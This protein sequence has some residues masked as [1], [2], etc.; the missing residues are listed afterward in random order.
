MWLSKRRS[1]PGFALL[2]LALTPSPGSA[3]VVENW[4]W[5]L[6]EKQKKRKI[7]WCLVVNPPAAGDA[8]AAGAEADQWKAWAKAAFQKWTDA[9]TG[10]S[11][12]EVGVLDSRCQIQ[13]RKSTSPEKSFG[14]AVVPSGDEGNQ[15][16]KTI[17]L[18]I[19]FVDAEGNTR[20]WG[21]EGDD[22]LD[23]I[24]LLAHEIGHCLRLNDTSDKGDIMASG[25]ET[26]AEERGN[27]TTDLS[28]QDKQEARDSATADLRSSQFFVEPQGGEF[29]SDGV[30]VT[31]PPEAFPKTTPVS[32]TLRRKVFFPSPQALEGEPAGRAVMLYAFAI[33]FES[34]PQRPLAARI[35]VPAEILSGERV[36]SVLPRLPGAV[37]PETLGAF[38]YDPQQEVWAR[39]AAGP[40]FE[41]SGPG[42]YGVGGIVSDEKPPRS[43]SQSLWAIV[44]AAGALALFVLILWRRKTAARLG[45]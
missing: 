24:R 10:W 3:H 18:Y 22:K 7:H 26:E 35:E 21:V 9:A 40:Q 39:I 25:V 1:L 31:A 33:E 6:V 12:E 2:L 42:V 4:D 16:A 19:H 43:S 38:R 17:N 30:Y 44:L 28:E 5:H 41:I 13:I 20:E 36:D 8:F 29:V 23:P 27:H 32:V 15:R 34:P 37:D 11:F 45:R 14:R